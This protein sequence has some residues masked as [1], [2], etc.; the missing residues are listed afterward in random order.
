MSKM[1]AAVYGFFQNL[2]RLI[3]PRTTCFDCH[4]S[5]HSKQYAATDMQPSVV[6]L[7][8]VF[9]GYHCATLLS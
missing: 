2:V 9:K 8:V 5:K 7:H 1:S 4:I 6:L 3:Y